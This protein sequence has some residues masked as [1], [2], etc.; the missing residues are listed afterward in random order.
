MADL[1]VTFAGLALKSPLIVEFCD[2]VPSIETAVSVSESGAGALLLPPLD[3]ARLNWSRN[4]DEVTEHNQTDAALRETE[5]I[6]RN[7]NR[8]AYMDAIEQIAGAVSI[9]V[10]AALQCVN[11]SQW[12]NTARIMG[13]A[14]AA[15]VEVHPLV[16][17]DWRT[18]R[19]DRIEKEIIRVGASVATR[20]DIPVITRL[21]AAPYGMQTIVQSLGE[22]NVKGI[23]LAGSEYL[24]VIDS[25]SGTT[26]TQSTD[27]RRGDTAFMN[28][29]ASLQVLY[30]R[31]SPHLAARIAS[32]R[33]GALTESILAGATL[34]V[35]PLREGTDDHIPE[36]VGTHIDTLRRW[37]KDK[38]FSS[39]FDFRGSLSESRRSS[40]LENP[41]ASEL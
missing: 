2:Q 16:E 19:S 5:R 40:S 18:S 10:V 11:R 39:L 26:D 17:S 23:V 9:P 36:L 28:S 35:L 41:A 4:E 1:N 21:I 29:L 27:G 38:R 32:D 7:V 12:I 31:V 20:L 33:P 34:A 22:S 14:G 25:A 3:E 6:R 37:M 8:G 30:R 15:A 13:D 24:T